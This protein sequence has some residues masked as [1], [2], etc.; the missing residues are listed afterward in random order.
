MINEIASAS[1][2]QAQAVAQVTSGIEQISSVVQK[3]SAT[4]SESADAS[5]ELN[6]QAEK[7]QEQ[8]RQ[9]HLRD[10]DGRISQSTEEGKDHKEPDASKETDLLEKGNRINEETEMRGT[11][12]ISGM[13]VMNSAIEQEYSDSPY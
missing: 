9:F 11:E 10:M 3:N 6:S 4:A 13:Q 2:D 1:E 7:L 12:E 5:T 8:I